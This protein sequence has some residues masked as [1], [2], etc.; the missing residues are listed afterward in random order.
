MQRIIIKIVKVLNHIS[1]LCASFCYQCICYLIFYVNGV[2][3]KSFRSLGI[4]YIHKSLKATISIGSNFRMN[5]GSKY[6]DSGL[7]G[8]CRIEVR[9]TAVLF[10]GDN[11][12]MSDTTITCHEKII[13]GNNVIIGVGSQIRDTDNHS[14]N[15][16]DRL[17]GLD[18]KN[19]KTAPILINDNVFIGANS[20]ILK[21]VIIGAN[22]ILGAG[23]V[24]TKNVPE[25]EIWAGNPAKFIKK[26]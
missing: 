5:N 26:I 3:N 20:F 21:G 13:I 15:P 17:V 7:N 4:P 11:V 23:S 24:L 2:N 22:S 25:N 16:I 6:S 10:I 8:K 19:K 1:R 12:G 9:D 18:W 14:L